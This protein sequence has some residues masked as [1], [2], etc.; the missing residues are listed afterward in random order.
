MGRQLDDGASALLKKIA[1]EQGI[2]IR[3]NAKISAVEGETS[4]AGVRMDDGEVIPAELVIISA[5]VRANTAVADKAGIKIDRSVVVNEK[6]ETSEEDIYACGD[7]A[8]YQ[9]INYAIW[10]QALEMGKVAGANAAGDSLVYETVPA[11]LSFHGMNTSLYAIGD[12]GKK[13]E[14]KYKKAELADEWKNTYEKYYFV[15]NRLAGQS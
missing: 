13:P 1:E 15:N 2:Q 7:C 8:Q 6:M 9:G 12:P 11:A 10:P 4:A 5:G 3:L 14:T